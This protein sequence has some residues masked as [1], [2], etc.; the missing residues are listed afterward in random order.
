MFQK[1]L[2]LMN[3]VQQKG[4]VQS[5]KEAHELHE[6]TLKVKS[7]LENNNLDLSDIKIF[8][9]YL[10]LTQRRG[11]FSLTDASEI[12]KFV[13]SLEETLKKSQEKPQEKSLSTI[14]ELE[15]LTEDEK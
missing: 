5:L 8:V 3:V 2:A 12:Y 15:T 10:E 14:S 1:L 13:L 9:D 4:S 6:R 7:D 11:Q